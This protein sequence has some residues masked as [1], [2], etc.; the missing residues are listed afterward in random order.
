MTLISR[1]LL[2]SLLALGTCFTAL[3]CEDRT[4]VGSTCPNGV[5]PNALA[6]VREDDACLVTTADSEIAITLE[7]DEHG[8]LVPDGWRQEG[9]CLPGELK[10]GADGLTDVEVLYALPAD[11]TPRPRCTDYP[12][13]DSSSAVFGRRLACSRIPW[14]FRAP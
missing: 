3:A 9:V 12:F 7:V 13:L 2:R 14:A 5:C 1:V 8:E 4:T 10:R 11:K 6:R